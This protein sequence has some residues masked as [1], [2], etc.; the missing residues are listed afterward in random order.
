[1]K[2]KGK[3]EWERKGKEKG[4]EKEKKKGKW[5]GKERE[6]WKEDSLRKVG[7]TH[8]RTHAHSGDFIRCPMLC[9]VLDRQKCVQGAFWTQKKLH[10]CTLCVCE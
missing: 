3:W 4:K 1:M 6:K 9:I 2:G 7:R 8:A 10:L 5:K